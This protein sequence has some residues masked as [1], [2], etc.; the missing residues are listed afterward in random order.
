MIKIE[1]IFPVSND[2]QMKKNRGYYFS[3]RIYRAESLLSKQFRILKHCTVYS[4]AAIAKSLIM[5]GR[6]CSALKMLFHITYMDCVIYIYYPCRI[7]FIDSEMDQRV[8]F[9]KRKREETI[10]GSETFENTK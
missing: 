6:I 5:F 2:F 8:L 7:E 3:S 4:R 9:K 1:N 10:D